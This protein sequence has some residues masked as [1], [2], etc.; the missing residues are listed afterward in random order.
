MFMLYAMAA[1]TLAG[2]LAGG[3]LAALGDLRVRWAAFAVAGLLV[4]VVLFFGPVAERIGELGMPLYIGSTL[5]V[6]GVVVRNAR[7]SGMAVIA[8]GAAANLAAIAANGGAMPAS[9][10]A[11]AVL[12]R[13][14]NDGY[15]NSVISDS[16]ALWMLTDIF[17]IPPP[18]P[19]AN[20]FSIGDVLIA[21][22]V[23]WLIASTMAAGGAPRNLP[24]SY[25]R[26]RTDER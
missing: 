24:P 25:S 3:S 22:G 17:A 16:P 8:L 2:W 5:V 9:P 26:P 13:G 21:L 14:L 23:A 19:F 4:Q 15:S 10:A 6:L 18:I 20:V 12:G 7:V 1:G 11:L